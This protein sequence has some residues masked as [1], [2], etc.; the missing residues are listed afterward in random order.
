MSEDKK[1][2][3]KKQVLERISELIDSVEQVGNI[4]YFEIS[5]KHMDG[6]LMMDLRNTYKEKVR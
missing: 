4:N 6:T 5:I 3:L 2:Q 1:T